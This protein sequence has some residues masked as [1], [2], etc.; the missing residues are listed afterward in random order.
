MA[1]KLENI[2]EFGLKISNLSKEDIYKCYQCGKC[3]AG[4]PVASDMP[5]KPS[6]IMRFIQLGFKDM[7]LNSKTIWMCASCETCSERC[8]KG[9]DIAKIMDTL[10]VL[11]REE[12]YKPGVHEV[13]KFNDI[14]LNQINSLGRI[15]ESLLAMLF[16]IKSGHFFQDASLGLKLFTRGKLVITPNKVK[17]LNTV[18]NI[19]NKSKITNDD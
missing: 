8:P 13:P 17:E 7:I 19:F 1:E 11:C 18:E 12:G 5:H 16:N 2:R 14:F 15:H 6:Q 4:C 9:I 10:R 3:T